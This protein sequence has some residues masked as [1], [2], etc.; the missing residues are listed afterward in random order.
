MKIII[1]K[2][3]LDTCLTALIIEVTEGDEVHVVKGTASKGNLMDPSVLCIEAGGSG[4]TNLNNFDHHD[5]GA[6]LPPAC[7]QAFEK[8]K[9][10]MKGLER[11]IEYVCAVDEA[12]GLPVPIPFPSLSNIFSGM[13]LVEKDR[14][15]QFFKGIAILRKALE[16]NID[17]F[18]TMPDIE[19]W[20][21]YRS[22]K[23]EN[24]AQ[25]AQALKDTKFHQSKG[26]LKM[27]YLESDSI[28]GIGALYEQGCQVVVMYSP[29][30]GNPP[31]RK[32]TIAGNG[33]EVYHLVEHFNKVE[34]DWGGQATII[35]SPRSGTRI[36]VEQV[37]RTVK[38]YM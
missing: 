31:V 11:L 19:D 8:V 1:Q 14:K 2:P 36:D 7:R 24:M 12:R 13:L 37:I 5:V 32:F 17:P 28:G 18:G 27:G 21:L 25:V 30:F 4:S 23:E 6:R 26:G 20:R 35:G 10:T 22:V 29:S 38:E 34:P 9:P 33:V 15:E 16:D 3:D